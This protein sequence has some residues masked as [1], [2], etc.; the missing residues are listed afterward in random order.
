MESCHVPRRPWRRGKEADRRLPPG[1]KPADKGTPARREAAPPSQDNAR[2]LGESRRPRAKTLEIT[3]FGAPRARRPLCY[4][5]DVDAAAL[6]DEALLGCALPAS[7]LLPIRRGARASSPLRLVC[8]SVLRRC[9][10][11]HW[12]SKVEGD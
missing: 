12:S 3:W 7:P 2:S 8:F 1:Q 5:D 10:F 9:F 11:G 6:A 4:A